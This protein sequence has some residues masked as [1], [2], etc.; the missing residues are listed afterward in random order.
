MREQAGGGMRAEA[1]YQK[2]A[3][4]GSGGHTHQWVFKRLWQYGLDPDGTPT[5]CW[6]PS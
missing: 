3:D 4:H 1:L 6:A 2:G 5:P